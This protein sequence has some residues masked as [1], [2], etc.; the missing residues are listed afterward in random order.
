MQNLAPRPTLAP[1]T[2]PQTGERNHRN[3]AWDP[4]PHH[5]RRRD[6]IGSH[7]RFGASNPGS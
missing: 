6:E 2:R 5:L 4:S 7:H 3:P 1:K